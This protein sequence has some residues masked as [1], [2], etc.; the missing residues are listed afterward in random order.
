[1]IIYYTDCTKPT[2]TSFHRRFYQFNAGEDWKSAIIRS[3]RGM[4]QYIMCE[5]RK[6]VEL[7]TSTDHYKFLTECYESRHEQQRK[8]RERDEKRAAEKKDIKESKIHPKI[9]LAEDDDWWMDHN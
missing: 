3:E 6:I 9:A 2:D 4:M 7:F 1:M 8:I 5:P